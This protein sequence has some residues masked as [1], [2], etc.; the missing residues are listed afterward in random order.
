M[1]RDMERRRLVC[2]VRGGAPPFRACFGIRGGSFIR[3]HTPVAPTAHVALPFPPVVPER[4]CPHQRGMSVP[5]RGMSVLPGQR[6][7][8]VARA[9]TH[10]VRPPFMCIS[11]ARIQHAH[12]YSTHTRTQDSEPEPGRPPQGQ[13]T[14]NSP[15]AAV[16][17]NVGMLTR[18]E[19]GLNDG[20]GTHTTH[21]CTRQTGSRRLERWCR[22]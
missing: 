4:A 16:G 19:H 6:V 3:N 21:T 22:A 10:L 2:V 18:A 9:K 7:E 8:H 1:K 12:A 13:R 15:F 5:R 20:L 17:R 11:R 14:L